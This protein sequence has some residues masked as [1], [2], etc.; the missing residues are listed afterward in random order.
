VKFQGNDPLS[1]ALT[2]NKIVPPNVPFRLGP[3][4]ISDFATFGQGSKL[5]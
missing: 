4:S 3:E 2:T 5:H 1:Q